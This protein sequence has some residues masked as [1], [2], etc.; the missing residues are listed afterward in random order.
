MKHRF[1][2]WKKD[3][4][5]RLGYEDVK[6]LLSEFYDGVQL[7][8]RR[9]KDF[10]CLITGILNLPPTYRGKEG[11]YSCVKLIFAILLKISATFF[12]KFNELYN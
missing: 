12:I 4:S 9:T 5:K 8:K 2:G 6:K 1:E 3:D 7:F 10:I 11:N